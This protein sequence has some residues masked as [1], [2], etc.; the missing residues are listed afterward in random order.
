[1]SRDALPGASSGA[2]RLD[3]RLNAFR[4]DLADRRLA[5]IVSA[6]HYAAGRLARVTAGCAAVRRAPEAGAPVDTYYHYGEQ[7]R[8][9]DE[10]GDWAWCQSLADGY[11]GYVERDRLAEPCRTA[12][13]HYVATCGSYLYEGPDLRGHPL[14][15]LPRHSSVAVAETGLVT[16]GTEYAALDTGGCLPLACL[17]PTPS[18]SADLV[19]AARLYLGCPYLWA[20][21]SFLGLDCSGLVQSAFRDIGIAVLRD[22][23]MQRDTIGAEISVRSETELRPGDLL[24]LPGH[25][26]I[27]AGAGAVI[28]ADGLSMSVREA[29]LSGLLAARGLALHDFVVR[30]PSAEPD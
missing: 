20:G 29:S 15:F 14:D 28:H 6:P 1:M 2:E 5:G 13:T 25:V 11:V 30:R 23:D 16:R 18:R 17:S 7:V 19:A 9:F 10:A 27:C 26:L 24:Y 12:P 8:V 21:R 3:P 4:P 22:T